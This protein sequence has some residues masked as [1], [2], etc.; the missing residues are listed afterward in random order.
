MPHSISLA[1]QISFVFLA[2]LNFY[3]D[4]V[5]NFDAIAFQADNFL[6][7]IG[8]HSHFR[9]PEVSENLG[10]DAIIPQISFKAELKIGFD[11]VDPLLV[12]KLVSLDLVTFSLKYFV[13]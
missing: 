2:G 6:R 3:R 13:I 9:H 10:S 11:G 7:V 1:E 5:D 4:P 12:L 8:Q